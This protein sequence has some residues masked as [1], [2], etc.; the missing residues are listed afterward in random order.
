VDEEVGTSSATAQPPPLLVRGQAQALPQIRDHLPCSLLLLPWCCC[1]AIAMKTRRVEGEEGA[2]AC[3][4]C[5][6]LANLDEE[7]ASTSDLLYGEA[8]WI[9]YCSPFYG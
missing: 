4:L 1:S 3:W 8:K 2:M 7:E 6:L 9:C 5:L